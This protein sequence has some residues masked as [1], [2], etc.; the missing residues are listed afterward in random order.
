[1]TSTTLVPIP[2]TIEN[3]SS[4]RSNTRSRTSQKSL[5]LRLS[6]ALTNQKINEKMETAEK[7]KTTQVRPSASVSLTSGASSGSID[8]LPS[9]ST[10]ISPKTRRASRSGAQL[11]VVLPVES[12][13]VVRMESIAG[14]DLKDSAAGRPP[15]EQDSGEYYI[16][17]YRK[18]SKH[19]SKWSEVWTTEHYYTPPGSTD[20]VSVN[21]SSTKKHL[22]LAFREKASEDKVQMCLESFVVQPAE[23]D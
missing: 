21:R 18:L 10:N 20:F 1:M 12:N 22:P 14:S 7:Q 6:Q 17:R 19:A 4:G 8:T 3:M 9:W 23:E 13:G 15:L 11:P 16:K 2:T 5:E